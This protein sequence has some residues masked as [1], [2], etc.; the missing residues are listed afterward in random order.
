M[1]SG[2]IFR[3]APKMC[4]QKNPKDRLIVKRFSLQVLCDGRR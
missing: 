3:Q 2:I 4:A 1:D